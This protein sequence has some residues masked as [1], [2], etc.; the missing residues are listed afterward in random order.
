M[1]LPIAR[2]SAMRTVTVY[3]WRYRG[4]RGKLTT[5]SFHC[6][7]ED[8]RVEHPDAE[9]VEGT[10]QERQVHDDSDGPLFGPARGGKRE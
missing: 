7:E 2:L 3:R 8:I 10:R 1:S 9:P 4:L 6:T 5:T